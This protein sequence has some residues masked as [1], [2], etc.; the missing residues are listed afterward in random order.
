MGYYNPPVY[1]LPAPIP[2]AR[3]VGPT[4]PYVGTAKSSRPGYM[5]YEEKPDD[6]YGSASQFNNNN[7]GSN[8][9]Q[10]NRK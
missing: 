6:N 5:F 2:V 9:F 8:F 4:G 3:G 1:G 7:Y 10:A